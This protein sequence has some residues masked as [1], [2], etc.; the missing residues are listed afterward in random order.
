MIKFI[1]TTCSGCGSQLKVTKGK[2][3][4]YKLMCRNSECDGV[5][6]IKFQK[7]MLA[8][9]ISGIGPSI[10]KKLY[11][12]G[13]RNIVDLLQVTSEKLINSGEFKDGRSLEKILGAIKSVKYVKLSAII[14]SLQ[15]ENVG[16][17]ISKE[18]EKFY[19]GLPYDFTGFNY[20]IREQ[21]QNENSD[22]MIKIKEMVDGITNNTDVKVIFPKEEKTDSSFDTRIME[23]TGSPKD[24]GFKTKGDFVK[25]VAKYGVVHGK[26]NKDCH[27]LVTDDLVSRTSKM[28]KAEKLGV[29]VV[30]YGQL[31]EILKN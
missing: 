4:K 22:M 13:V 14:E 3:D 25:E 6:V 23:M 20:S 5:S 12:A 31:I 19:C 1:P 8:F 28:E 2:N 24:F 9:E 7:G 21:I 26:L 30:T 29:Q 16:N 11:N 18:I 17:T 15:F 27:F 10:Y